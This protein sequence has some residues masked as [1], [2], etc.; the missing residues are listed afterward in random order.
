MAARPHVTEVH[1]LHVWEIS[2]DLPAASAH[3]L[4]DPGEDCHAVRADLEGL[5]SREY[6]ISHTTLQV[7]HAALALLNVGPAALRL[8][9]AVRRTGR[10]GGFAARSSRRALR[11][12]PAIARPAGARRQ[13]LRQRLGPMTQDESR[14]GPLGRD[15]PDALPGVPSPG[16]PDARLRMELRGREPP[17]ARL[18]RSLP[19]ES[20]GRPR[21]AGSSVP[22]GVLLQAAAELHLVG[23]PQ[24]S[25]GPQSAL[26]GGLA[27]PLVPGVQGRRILSLVNEDKLRRILARMLDEE[28][29]LGPHGIR[30]ISRWHLDQP[31]TFDVAG[32]RVPR[33]STSRPSRPPACSAAT[34]TGAGRCGSRSTCSLIRALLQHYRYYGDGLK[35]ECPTGSGTDDDAVRGGPGAVAPPRRDIP[36]GRRRA[37]PRLRRDQAIPGGPALA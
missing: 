17:G 25:A 19:A 12:P 13:R 23:E 20:G 29:F 30:S 35:V 34:L 37:A 24:G 15:R 32:A 4:V 21:P 8:R 27:D 28:R 36:A 2:S 31:Y 5:L 1:D 16:R 33:C 22:A 6:G 14:P 3:V 26:R 10:T 18:R 11:P 9:A 7:D